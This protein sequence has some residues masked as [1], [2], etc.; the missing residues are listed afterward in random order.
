M[1]VAFAV[2][3]RVFLVL[4]LVLSMQF[5][6][7]QFF[8]LVAF[9]YIRLPKKTKV[10]KILNSQRFSVDFCFIDF[11]RS[12][13]TITFGEVPPHLVRH[14]PKI[15][16]LAFELLAVSSSKPL[17]FTLDEDLISSP[18]SPRTTTARVLFHFLRF[19]GR[20]RR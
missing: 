12:Y 5:L 19:G 13:L 11:R 10:S 9:L 17:A 7:I 1:V 14:D 16:A 20:G 8:I 3:L 2:Y 6:T 15:L 4:V 18:D